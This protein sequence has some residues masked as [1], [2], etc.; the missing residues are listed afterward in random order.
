MLYRVLVVRLTSRIWGTGARVAICQE[1]GPRLSDWGSQAASFLSQHWAEG[2]P[3]RQ[4][5][6]EEGHWLESGHL[7]LNSSPALPGAFSVK[8]G[9]GCED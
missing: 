2:D 8:Q 3:E 4:P 5:R 7:G 1:G 6:G 9:W